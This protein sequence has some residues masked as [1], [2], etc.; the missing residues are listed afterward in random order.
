MGNKRNKQDLPSIFKSDNQLI[1]GDR[2]I[3]NLI[4]KHFTTI[5]PK[6]NNLIPSS[7]QIATDNIQNPLNLTFSLAKISENKTLRILQSLKKKTS[8]SFDGLSNKLIKGIALGIYK[9]LTKVINKS[10]EEGICPQNMKIAKIIP[11]FM[12]GNREDPNNY[13]PI[14]L[15]PTLSKILEKV[16]YEQVSNYFE[17][18]FLS[19]FQFGFRKRHETMHCVLNFL[20]NIYKNKKFK[21]HAAIFIDLKKAFDTVPH[22]LLLKK[23]EKYGFSKNSISWFNSYLS[24]RY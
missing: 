12:S 19:N 8:C 6:L 14:S 23:L 2:R 7:N 13:R 21:Y 9:P 16:I 10:I 4:N 20:N 3:A 1:T 15:L 18:N 17:A 22:G 5:G 11:L 24:N